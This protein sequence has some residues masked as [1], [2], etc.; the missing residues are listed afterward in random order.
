MVN[1]YVMSFKLNLNPVSGIA[2]PNIHVI[3]VQ[4]RDASVFL[5][6]QLMNDVAALAVGQ[7]QYNGWL[8]PQGRVMALFQL[9]KL[10]D[11]QY[12]LVL[13]NLTPEW[14]ID[15]LKR[16]VFR[17]KLS[18]T[19]VTNL[20]VTGE[21]LPANTL[22]PAVQEFV[23]QIE[24]PIILNIPNTLCNRRLTLSTKEAV[25]HA[26]YY[27]QWH[28][29]DMAIGWPWID[30]NLQNLWT[31]QMLSLQTLNAFSLKKGCYPGQEIVART[32]YLGKSKRHLVSVAG[33]NLVNSQVVLQNG[34][35]IG[36]VVNANRAGDFA[37]AVL[38]M[39]LTENADIVNNIGTLEIIS[40]G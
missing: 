5:Q 11:E 22:V 14:L 28:C 10:S 4:G 13:N 6:A 19:V 35:E 27:D 24:S 31:P 34:Q 15:N 12:L 33:Q 16:F 9:L 39:H 21:I 37:I 3:Y 30:N 36:K 17:S 20:F 26:D 25:C 38:P 40:F 23:G 18:F 29:L 8:T 2:L 7:W 1:P 32:H